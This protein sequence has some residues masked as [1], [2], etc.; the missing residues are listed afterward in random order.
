MLF[1]KILNVGLLLSAIGVVAGASAQEN[2]SSESYK[3]TLSIQKICATD[4]RPVCKKLLGEG[5]NPRFMTE[6]PARC[7]GRYGQDDKRYPCRIKLTANTIEIDFVESES[8]SPETDLNA[9]VVRSAKIPVSKIFSYKYY[10][11]MSGQGI[12]YSGYF[13]IGFLAEGESKSKGDF[14]SIFSSY[15]NLPMIL[16]I[17]SKI[18]L[19]QR[20]KP[21]PSFRELFFG[22]S[23]LSDVPGKQDSLKRLLSQR[24][25]QYCDLSGMDLRNLD[26]QSTNLEGANFE[27]SNL[28]NSNLKSAYLLGANFRNANLTRVNLVDVRG[29]FSDFSGVN[30]EKANLSGGNFRVSKFDGAVFVS[31]RLSAHGLLQSDFRMSSLQNANFKGAS[32]FGSN[33]SNSDLRQTIWEDANLNNRSGAVTVS[34]LFNSKTTVSH[35]TSIVNANLSNA[36]LSKGNFYNVVLD[37]SDLRG[38]QALNTILRETSLRG[39][40]LSGIDLT[41]VDVRGASVQGTNF[42]GA[43]LLSSQIGEFKKTKSSLDGLFNNAK[44]IKDDRTTTAP[45]E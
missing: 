19:Q 5:V 39:T 6:A 23:S 37:G 17:D 13:D 42:S 30:F 44:L 8:R 21:E 9:V 4:G 45:Q 34:S 25:C 36:N 15:L 16:A 40:N 29:M 41:K 32:I 35:R 38:S 26:L 24:A 20:E 12:G 3:S 43:T 7:S 28:E 27:N 14:I 1:S 18:S 11:W 10:D 33:F 31:S 2:G 22:L